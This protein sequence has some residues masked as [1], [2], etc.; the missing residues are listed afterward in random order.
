MG[1]IVQF[2]CNNN[3]IPHFAIATL[4]MIGLCKFLIFNNI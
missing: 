4:P 1:E 3:E 2:P